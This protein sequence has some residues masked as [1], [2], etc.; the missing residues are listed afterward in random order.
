MNPNEHNPAIPENMTEDELVALL[1]H[2]CETGSQH[3]NLSVGEETKVQTVNSTECNPQ[4][5]ACAIPTMG[6]DPDEDEEAL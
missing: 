5:G 3:I 6:E 1:D 2:L 4:L